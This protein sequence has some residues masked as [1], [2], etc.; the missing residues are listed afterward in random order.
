MACFRDGF[1]LTK[2]RKKERKKLVYITSNRFKNE[3]LE[4]MFRGMV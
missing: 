2:E 3:K 4:N 1:L